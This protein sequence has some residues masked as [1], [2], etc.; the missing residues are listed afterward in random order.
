MTCVRISIHRPMSRLVLQM[1]PLFIYTALAAVI[2]EI[3]WNPGNSNSEGEQ[4]TVRV[5]GVSSYR[6]RLKYQF[7]RLLI[8]Y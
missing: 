7:S 8:V 4:K 6:G 5:R 1:T 2:L 3:Q